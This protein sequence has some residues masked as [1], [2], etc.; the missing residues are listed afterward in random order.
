[1]DIFQV[2]VSTINHFPKRIRDKIVNV[3]ENP[4]FNRIRNSI[5]HTGSSDDPGHIR[6]ALIAV[7]AYA[8]G[9]YTI[10]NRE[11][12]NGRKIYPSESLIW[13]SPSLRGKVPNIPEST[14]MYQL[15]R[16]LNNTIPFLR[17][18]ELKQLQLEIPVSYW[19]YDILHKQ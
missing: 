4:S 16:H 15:K 5:V 9:I 19:S 8:E 6:T 3:N 1:M 14:V 10:L 12:D 13:A 2:K 11:W 17:Q 7:H 18:E